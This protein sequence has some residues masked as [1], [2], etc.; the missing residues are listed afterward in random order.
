M[1]ELFAFHKELNIKKILIIL[2]IILIIVISIFFIHKSKT[3]PDIKVNKKDNKSNSIFTSDDGSIS[4][5]FSS[6]YNFSKYTPIQDYILEL[7]SDNNANIFISKK[8]ILENRDLKSIVTSDRTSYIKE[9]KS[10]SNL[11][12]IAELTLN[13]HQ[14]FSY[15]FH[16]LDNRTPY[17]LQIIWVQIENSYYIIDIE[18]PLDSLETNSNI[19]TNLLTTFKIIDKKES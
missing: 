12:D 14:A 7:R 9:F 1:N 6:E 8:D 2:I 13:N 16:Y 5:E 3:S 15:S 11:S 18:F 10:Y 4:L 17:Y 19:I